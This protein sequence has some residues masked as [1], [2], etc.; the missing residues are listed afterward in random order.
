[1]ETG[2]DVPAQYD[3]VVDEQGRLL[4]EDLVINNKNGKDA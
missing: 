1:M 2:Y 3:I 4:M